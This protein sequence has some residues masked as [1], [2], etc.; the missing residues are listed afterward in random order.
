MEHLPDCSF[1]KS[2]IYNRTNPRGLE[3]STISG[4]FTFL[5]KPLNKMYPVNRTLK[6][7]KNPRDWTHYLFQKT[8]M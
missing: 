4:P 5:K 2:G 7:F 8:E 3:I 1:T 6:V